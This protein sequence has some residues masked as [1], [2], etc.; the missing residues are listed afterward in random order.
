MSEEKK[1]TWLDL[2]RIANRIP[3]NLLKNPVTIWRDEDGF[4]IIGVERL[5]QNY[6]DDGDCHVCPV[7]DM[8]SGDPEYWKENSDDHPVVHPKGTRILIA[9]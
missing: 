9:E 8:K 1:F 6:V 4:Q 2:K 5:K 7:S 3:A